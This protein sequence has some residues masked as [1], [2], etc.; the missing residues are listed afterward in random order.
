MVGSYG[1]GSSLNSYEAVSNG[2]HS[3]PN[4]VAKVLTNDD[5]RSE[6][7]E[8]LRNQRDEVQY[9]LE[10]NSDLIDALRDALLEREELLGDDI[11]SVL[12]K[13]LAE[14]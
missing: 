3:S 11:K 6:V 7:E 1:M 9:L 12:E 8:L 4:I 10:K 2:G 13:A 5:A 14:R